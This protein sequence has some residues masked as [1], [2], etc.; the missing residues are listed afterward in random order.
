MALADFVGDDA[1]LLIACRRILDRQPSC[2][3]LVWLAAHILG[4]P[5]QRQALWTAVEEL[6][7]DQTLAAL[8]YELGDDPVLATI[9]WSD[10]L[11]DLA[12]KRGDLGFVVVDTDGSVEYQVDRLDDAGHA[13]T[14][15]DAEA[16]AQG[17][18]EANHLLIEF[19]AIGPEQGL[20][21]V[22]SFAAAAVA[23]HLNVP[24]W[25]VAE[26][27]VALGERMYGGLVR[28]W[29]DAAGEPRY[30]RPLEE[31]P[32]SLLDQVITAN[33][34]GT[35]DQAQQRGGCPI[36]PELF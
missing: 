15:V 13:M 8:A 20:A 10:N 2:G 24:V 29:N 22:G 26:T 16:T 5:N 28:R 33:G 17:L 3:P 19:T 27:G 11:T 21:P 9:G 32:V 12:R 25:G 1:S 6:E 31:V 7:E 4:A 23:K 30:R 36:V 18:F 14:L 35:A 34:A